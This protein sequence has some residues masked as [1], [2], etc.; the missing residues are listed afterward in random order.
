MVAGSGEGCPVTAGSVAVGGKE[1]GSVTDGGEGC[2]L[3]AGSVAVGGKEVGSVTNG[4]EGS[5]VTAGRL[6]NAVGGKHSGWWWRER[7]RWALWLE[8]KRKV[9]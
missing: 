4:R 9:L 8:V 1:V 2:P 5:P 3:T 6:Y 7:W